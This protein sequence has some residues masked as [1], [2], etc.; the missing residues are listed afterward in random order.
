MMERSQLRLLALAIRTNNGAANEVRG[1]VSFWCAAILR[2]AVRDSR[3]DV[4]RRVAETPA[5]PMFL[6]KSR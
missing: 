1:A 5:S 6:V 4:R 2:C 3:A